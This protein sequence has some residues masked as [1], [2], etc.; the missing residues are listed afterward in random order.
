[1]FRKIR[2]CDYH[3]NYP[4]FDQVSDECKDL[5][6]QLLEHNEKKRP[7]GIKALQHRWF[8]KF[9]TRSQS[10]V[11]LNVNVLKHMKSYRGVSH[12]HRAA[13]NILVKMS[14]DE[15]VKDLRE[16]FQALDK[17]GDGMIEAREV[18]KILK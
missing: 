14:T 6:K 13:M 17:D 12:L 3:F 16:T 1:M 4:E 11:N 5:I 18:S 9:E 15:E 10:E 8:K 2:E 7:T